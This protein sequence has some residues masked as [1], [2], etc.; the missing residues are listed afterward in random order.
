MYLK[1]LR[2]TPSYAKPFARLFST[3]FPHSSKAYKAGSHANKGWEKFTDEVISQIS[4]R[5]KN[6]VFLLWVCPHGLLYCLPNLLEVA[7]GTFVVVVSYRGGMP[8]TRAKELIGRNIT[9]SWPVTL[10]R[11]PY[12]EVA[13]LDVSTFLKLTS[14]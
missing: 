1:Q 11:W 2:P 10:R 14:C 9:Y 4:S 12:R 7:E 13:G 8:R 3:R 5:K 6:V